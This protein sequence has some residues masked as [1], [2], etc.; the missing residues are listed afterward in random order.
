MSLARAL[1]ALSR[2]R[3]TGVLTVAGDAGSCGFAV[4]D[5]VPRA[6]SGSLGG[7]AALGDRLLREGSLDITHHA[8]TLHGGAPPDGPVGGWLVE[9]GLSRRG[10]VERALRLQM[11]ERLVR[12][13]RAGGLDYR[14]TPGD[15]SVG[16]AWLREPEAA[17]DLVLDSMRELLLSWPLARL[18]RAAGGHPVRLG[19]IGRL[20]L[21]RARLWPEELV[22]RTLLRRDEASDVRE[23]VAAARGSQ[24]ALRFVALLALLGALDRDP[25]R[26]SYGLLVRKRRQLRSQAAPHDLLEAGADASA[27]DA[28]RALHRLAGQLHPDRFGAHAPAGVID[29]SREVMDALAVAERRVRQRRA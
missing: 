21:E 3:A 5:G 22:V 16:V 13:G 12:V 7:P 24:R 6:A 10:A 14:F 23:L 1:L 11:R 15:A 18:A 27:A 4:A 2:A 19:A 17:E 9:H 25:G 8:H 29:A 26:R 28:R 20:L